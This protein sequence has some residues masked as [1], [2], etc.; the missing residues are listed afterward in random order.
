[1]EEK[2]THRT[3]RLTDWLILAFVLVVMG[4]LLTDIGGNV[5]DVLDRE[6]PTQTD[7]PGRP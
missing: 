2:T 6:R 1:M 5:K 4:L 3:T 7:Q